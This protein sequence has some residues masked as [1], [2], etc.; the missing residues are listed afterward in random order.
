MNIPFK[1]YGILLAKYLR[2]Q[3]SSV[4]L[5]TIT[6]L[7]S[8]GLQILNPQIL[9]YFIDAAVEGAA[10]QQLLTAAGLFIAIAF[11]TQLLAVSATYFGESVAWTATNALR[12]DLAA[13]CLHLDLSFH[14]SC[15]PGELVERVDGDVSAISRFF[16]QLIIHVLG[17][18]I[19]LG[20]ILVV[21]FFN[22]WRAGLTLS[23]FAL[24]ALSLLLSLRSY[25]IVP[26]TKYRQVSAEFFGFLGEHLAGREDI[27][28]NG[29]VSYVMHRFYQF[30][31]RWLPIYHKARFASTVLWGL[32]VGVFTIG[33]AIALALAAYLWNRQAITIGSAYLIFHYTNLLSQPIERIRE[34]LEELQQVAASV[35]RISDLL[36]V[37]SRLSVG[38]HVALPK[39]ELS[40]AFENVSF[41]YPDASVTQLALSNLS[42]YLPA[43]QVLGVL[44]HTG[45]GK[46]T[47]AR[48]L[49]RLYDPVLGQICLGNVATTE[50]PLV[51]LRQRVGLVTQDVQ[52]FQTTIRNNLTFFNSQ[53]DDA[54]IWATLQLLGL[55]SWLRS[56]PQGLD[57][58]LGSDNGGLSAGQAQL[59]A[60]ARIFLKD[61]GLAI[62]DEASSRLDPTTER[63]IENAVDLLLTRRTGIIIAHRLAT[64]QR[65][66]Q[67]LILERGQ[68]VEYGDR[69]A[70]ANDPRSRFSQL[71]QT[72]STELLA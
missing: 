71:L 45:S 64:V 70:L 61:P 49:L 29:A 40:V 8:I 53:I 50:T 24:L 54:Q 60:F 41:G 63:L 42:F 46:S 3:R 2:Q 5:L 57:T 9:G 30:L 16:S 7:G 10:S 47:L 43:G 52:L 34:E 55:D 68:L 69:Q 25:A 59:L 23:L 38:G 51:E 6:L 35:Y 48:L 56:L 72:G 62:L 66:D 39:A 36:Q 4:V 19:L 13:H 65:V 1:Q 32:S 21:L 28:A 15:T 14:K 11:L 37:Q 58:L 18:V 12:V 20:G 33:N 67:I 22:D 26:W 31:Q 27:R 44:G 17:N